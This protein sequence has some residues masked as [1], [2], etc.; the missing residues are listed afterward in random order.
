MSDL[1]LQY[2]DSIELEE[3]EAEAALLTRVDRKYAMNRVDAARALAGLDPET[4]VLRIAGRTSFGYESIYF[5]TPDLLSYHLTAHRRRR[6]FKVRTRSYLESDTAFLEV[7]T[8][9]SRDTTVKER[10]A[11]DTGARDRLDPPGREYVGDTLSAFGMEI[12]ETLD[13]VLL[14]SYVRTTLVPPGAGARVTID[15][16]LTWQDSG[17]RTLHLPDLVVI[18][19]KSR[20]GVSPVDRLLW[21]H[22]HRPDSISKYGTGLAA[23]RGDLPDN[24]WTRVLRRHFNPTKELRCVPA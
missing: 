11:Y 7:K 2:L 16:D 8:R 18:E 14:T 6:R 20:D 22:G 12:D 3:L 21:R 13:P 15:T 1:P 4:R 19:T 24:K 17:G 23:L 10:T 5:D 9:G